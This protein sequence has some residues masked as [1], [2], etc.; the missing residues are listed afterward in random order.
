MSE[1]CDAPAEEEMLPPLPVTEREKICFQIR[2][3]TTCR[4]LEEN[5]W[6]EQPKA[7]GLEAVF[8]EEEDDVPDGDTDAVRATTSDQDDPTKQVGVTKQVCV[9]EVE[10]LRTTWFSTDSRPEAYVTT[11]SLSF[12]PIPKFFSNWVNGRNLIKTDA[13]RARLDEQCRV[14]YW[15]IRK[16]A[17][18]TLDQTKKLTFE[19]PWPSPRSFVKSVSKET[20]EVLFRYHTTQIGELTD[21]SGVAQI[22]SSV[23]IPQSMCHTRMQFLALG[24]EDIRDVSRTVY[25]ELSVPVLS[26]LHELVISRQLESRYENDSSELSDRSGDGLDHMDELMRS[27]PCKFLHAS[28]VLKERLCSASVDRDFYDGGDYNEPDN[29]E[30]KILNWRQGARDTENRSDQTSF[31]RGQQSRQL[32]PAVVELLHRVVESLSPFFTPLVS[33]RGAAILRNCEGF[34][35]SS[36]SSS[37]SRTGEVE[38]IKPQEALGHGRL[39][40]DEN[41]KALWYSI[42]DF[43]QLGFADFPLPLPV[44][45]LHM[46]HPLSVRSTAQSRFSSYENVALNEKH[47]T[48]AKRKRARTDESDERADNKTR[49]KRHRADGETPYRLAP[50]AVGAASA[51]HTANPRDWLL[52]L[53]HEFVASTKYRNGTSSRSGA[54]RHVE[55]S[56]K[57]KKKTTTDETSHRQGGLVGG[58][59]HSSSR[60]SPNLVV[61]VGMKPSI[62]M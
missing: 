22:R 54:R 47:R 33:W 53:C 36:S 32:S 58:R 60:A 25:M 8:G 52:N 62:S 18:G 15:R 19:P 45:S 4:R 31:E 44:V 39:Y 27:I 55:A 20:R 59:I 48:T 37:V 34:S 49:S 50:P 43:V 2:K 38:I 7:E 26:P 6:R 1:A 61:L 46:L 23:E 35:V 12:P 51:M 24:S 28:T 30:A 41:C 42:V 21:P 3:G 29:G 13:Q 57:Q 5:K 10:R 56:V 11:L 14:L 40:Y 17:L 9:K 16:C